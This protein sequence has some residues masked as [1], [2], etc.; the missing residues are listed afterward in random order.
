MGNPNL[1]ITKQ[2]FLHSLCLYPLF[3]YFNSLFFLKRVDFFNLFYRLKTLV[4]KNNLKKIPITKIFYNTTFLKL[5]SKNFLKKKINFLHG[6]QKYWFLEHLAYQKTWSILNSSI[7]HVDFK[8]P[9][10]TYPQ[11]KKMSSVFYLIRYFQKKSYK[12]YKV[13]TYFL[14]SKRYEIFGKSSLHNVFNPKK[15]SPLFNLTNNFLKN[16]Y[17][18][19]LRNLYV[20]KTF[21]LLIVTFYIFSIYFLALKQKQKV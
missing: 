18:F 15:I 2:Y 10:L 13:F 20:L 1:I 6:S 21:S 11:K 14:K 16:F 4:Q 7:Y 5:K 17:S 9:V 19:F 12:F 3:Y 8:Y